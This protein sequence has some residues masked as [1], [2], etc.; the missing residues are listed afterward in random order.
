VKGYIVLAVPETAHQS[1]DDLA[2][3]FVQQQFAA[4]TVELQ[5]LES[6]LDGS[7]IDRLQGSEPAPEPVAG[8][9]AEAPEP[10]AEPE[11]ESESEGEPAEE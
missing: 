3:F 5:D 4:V 8:P 11:S 10:E 6:G 1:V 9:G 7:D 2:T